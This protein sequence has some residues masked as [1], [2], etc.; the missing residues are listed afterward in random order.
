MPYWKIT[1]SHILFVVIIKNAYDA[2][3]TALHRLVSLDRIWNVLN[4][5]G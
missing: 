1:E 4:M 5:L 3:L 2:G